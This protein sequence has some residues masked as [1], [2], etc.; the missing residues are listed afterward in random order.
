VRA[1]R[2][3][4]FKYVRHLIPEQPYVLPSS[5]RDQ[6]PMMQELLRL[7][8]AGALEGAP[9]LWFRERRDSEELF[10]TDADPH[11]I[12]NLADEPVHQQTLRRM[13]DALDQRLASGRDLGLVPEALLAQR[14]WP[15]GEQPRTQ[16]PRVEQRA[17]A[18]HLSSE[19]EGASLLWRRP[20]DDAW[21]L[22]TG[23]VPVE[24][25]SG[26]EAMA[27]RYGHLTSESVIHP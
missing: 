25:D 7:A 19:T 18:I 4:R 17:G 13:R 8:A 27:V 3:R 16:A 15:G 21:R 1:V 23:P 11:E 20:G 10:D 9:A 5:F 2:G 14:F 6:M 26:L 24:G 12:R 22:Y